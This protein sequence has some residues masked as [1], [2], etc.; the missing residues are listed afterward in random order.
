MILIPATITAELLEHA[1]GRPVAY[2]D[3]T[4]V[5]VF[6]YQQPDGIFVID[7]CTRDH[8]ICGRLCLL[9]DGEPLPGLPA[10]HAGRPAA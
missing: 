1:D 4:A 9:L 6:A 8:A 10:A 3:A 2:I 7:I 5:A